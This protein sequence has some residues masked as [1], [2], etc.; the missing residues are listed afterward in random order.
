MENN[1]AIQEPRQA[2]TFLGLN[3]QGYGPPTM[4]PCPCIVCVA[5]RACNALLEKRPIPGP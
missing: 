4:Q 5:I 2:G 3:P 1:L